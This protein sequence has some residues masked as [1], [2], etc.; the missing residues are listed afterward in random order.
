[1]LT[2]AFIDQMVALRQEGTHPDDPSHPIVITRLA[3]FALRRTPPTEYTPFAT[4]PPIIRI[5]YVWFHDDT[6]NESVAVVMSLGDKTTQQN[7]WHP[8][9]VTRIETI[10]VPDWERNH[11]NH[12]AIVRR[13]R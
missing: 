6:T 9:A 13:T 12:R 8:A 10:L 3:T 1:L 4:G 5:L 11:A 2:W 7:H